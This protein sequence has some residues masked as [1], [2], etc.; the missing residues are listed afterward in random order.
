[1]E[2]TNIDVQMDVD[3][4]DEEGGQGTGAATRSKKGGEPG[5]VASGMVAATRRDVLSDSSLS[6]ASSSLS[7]SYTSASAGLGSIETRKKLFALVS[8]GKIT[9]AMDLCNKEFPDVLSGDSPASLD[10]AFQLNCQQ[11]IECVRSSAPDALQFAQNELGQYGQLNPKYCDALQDIVALLAY[12]DPLNSPVAE[13]LSQQRREDIATSLNSFVLSRENLNP[14]SV[15]E[16]IA[17]QTSVLRDLL[18]ETSSKDKKGSA[19]VVFPKWS[20][21]SFVLP[22]K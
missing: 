2:D 9:E 10:V 21:S 17:R 22:V 13:Y 12:T 16:R 4:D 18:H 6:S 19:K 14:Q 3:E 15:I 20:L 7:S 1:M 11:F 8:A 5:V